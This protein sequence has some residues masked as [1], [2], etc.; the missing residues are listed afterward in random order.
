MS[1]VRAQLLVSGWWAGPMLLAVFS[2]SGC[3]GSG[4]GNPPRGSISAPRDRDSARKGAS[5]DFE[6]TKTK[7]K[8]GSGNL[9][10]KSGRL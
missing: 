2:L 3:L 7:T 10:G 9:G 8:A 6:S 5:E 4:D 1:R